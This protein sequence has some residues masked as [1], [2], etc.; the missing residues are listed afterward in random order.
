MTPQAA[1][2]A[3]DIGPKIAK[4][5]QSKRVPEAEANG[6]GEGV[7]KSKTKTKTKTKTPRD[8]VLK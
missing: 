5:H 6:E 1:A 3:K 2:Y 8:V 7:A 4:T